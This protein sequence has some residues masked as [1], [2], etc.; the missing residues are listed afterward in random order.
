MVRTVWRTAFLLLLATCSEDSVS[1]DSAA[2]VGDRTFPSLTP[3]VEPV[4][5][6]AI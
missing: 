6:G 5:R 2:Y 3:T 4:G 1:E